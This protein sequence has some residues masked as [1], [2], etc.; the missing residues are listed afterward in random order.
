MMMVVVS[1]VPGKSRYGCAE[2]QNASQNGDYGLLH[3]DI[4]PANAPWNAHFVSSTLPVFFPW[5][6]VYFF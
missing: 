2:Q 3:C 5:P 4:P 6:K 1:V